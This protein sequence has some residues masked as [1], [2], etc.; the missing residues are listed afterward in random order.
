MK[1]QFLGA[2]GTVTGSCYLLTSDSGESMLIDCGLFQGSK[3]LDKANFMPLACDVSQAVGMV[4]T[5]AHLDH[6]GRIPLLPNQGF[7]A[8][9]WMT[10]ATRDL[11][12]ISL[13][14]TAKIN[15]QDHPDNPLYEKEDVN[16]VLELCKTVNYEVP[17]SVGPFSIIMRD[18]GHILGSAS[19]EIVDNS[20]ASPKKVVFSGDIGNFP[21]QLIQTTAMI[22]SA[23]VVI[24][25]S[26][27]GD[28]LHPNE[29]AREIFTSEINAVEKNNGTL[30]IPCFAIQRTQEVLHDLAHLKKE[31]K[32]KTETPIYFDSP[33]AEK[34]TQVFEQYPELYNPEFAAEATH[35]TPFHFPGLRVV[36]SQEARTELSETDDA[37][38]IIAGSGMMTGGRILSHAKQYLPIDTTRLLFV[39][40]QAEGTLGRR[41]LE[42]E[43]SVSLKG[44]YFQVNGT[45]SQTRA[46]SSHADQPRLLQWLKHIHGV[47]KVFLTHGDIE[48]RKT[49]AQKI[50]TDLGIQDVMQPL[51]DQIIEI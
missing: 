27:Y 47:K 21:Q 10:P 9:I 5:H 28:R 48:P 39:G 40:Y 51:Q 25:E 3:E 33:M 18:A 34:V 11:T 17:F 36:E 24:M 29:D 6:C 41:I 2:A 15:A 19:V 46:L 14:D 44:E 4:L 7:H 8:P 38:V 26:T 45:V 42:G 43:Q 37:K 12:E 22:E 49:L 20:G 16:A 30:L 31:G 13:F 1:I 32:I 35:G 23:D 50:Q